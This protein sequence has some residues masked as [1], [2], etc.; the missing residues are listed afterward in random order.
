MSIKRK[1]Q[2]RKQRWNT[3]EIKSLNLFFHR[4]FFRLM[5]KMIIKARGYEKF[6]IWLRDAFF[7]PN[8][9]SFRYRYFFSFY[10]IL[11]VRRMA[12]KIA[13]DF[14][15]FLLS[16]AFVSS[17][18]EYQKAKLHGR[19]GLIELF[20]WISSKSYFLV[21]WK[22]VHIALGVRVIYLVFGFV[23]SNTSAMSGM[24]NR[25]TTKLPGC[26]AFLKV[27]VKWKGNG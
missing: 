14:L 16:L 27:S 6:I 22:F 13:T 12:W 2:S 25:P 7:L 19:K 1:V 5:Y 21:R 15:V 26:M 3:N 9:F 20:H 17:K 10:V 4:F 8:S 23:F 11:A 18:T 24:I